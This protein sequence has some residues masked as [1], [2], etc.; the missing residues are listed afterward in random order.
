MTCIEAGRLFFQ[1]CREQVHKIWRDH[2]REPKR[3]TWMAKKRE[4]ILDG[5]MPVS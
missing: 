1:V 2:S 4:H 3:V 5:A